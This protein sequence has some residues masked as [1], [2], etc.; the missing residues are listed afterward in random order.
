MKTARDVGGSNSGHELVVF[1][2]GVDTVTFADVRVEVHIHFAVTFTMPSISEL[3]WKGRL[4]PSVTVKTN[5]VPARRHCFGRR[6][7]HVL[8]KILP[9]GDIRF[10]C[11]FVLRVDHL[12]DLILNGDA[13]GAAS[14]P[15]AVR[16]TIR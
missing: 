9:S 16:A 3:D 2:D 7:A 10:T 14:R 11:S 1:T 13:K 5:N 15:P 8:T 6:D 4:K 12:P